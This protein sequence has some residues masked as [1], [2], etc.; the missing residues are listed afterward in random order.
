MVALSPQSQ[1]SSHLLGVPS[2]ERLCTRFLIS[3]SRGKDFPS[4]A[5]LTPLVA[6][7]LL[8]SL[9]Q[10]KRLN[11]RVLASFHGWWV[12]FWLLLRCVSVC[13]CMCICWYQQNSYL[14]VIGVH[15]TCISC[16]PITVYVCT[17]NSCKT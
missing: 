1:V 2:L 17:C 5:S 6:Q 7:R 14:T 4:C 10:E 9:M 15:S 11:S 3:S 13:M 16:T 12:G 8:G